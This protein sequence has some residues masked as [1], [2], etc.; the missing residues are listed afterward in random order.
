VAAGNSNLVAV[1]VTR[2]GEGRDDNEAFADLARLNLQMRQ[3]GDRITIVTAREAG[4]SP[5][6]RGPATIDVTVPTGTRVTVATSTG[7][8]SVTGVS[9]GLSAMVETGDIVVR[10]PR[11]VPFQLRGGGQLH[12][13]FELTP[14]RAGT[15]LPAKSA[16]A[17][18]ASPLL[19]LRTLHGS[20][21]LQR[22]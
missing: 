8:V 10:W 14:E 2:R 17:T 1:T 21:R 9:G 16:G 12:S 4:S 6:G 18:S 7:R 13:E 11:D 20:I 22:H 3:D 15:Q 19:F 5:P